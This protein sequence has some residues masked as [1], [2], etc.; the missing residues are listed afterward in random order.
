MKFER[1][2]LGIA[3][4]LSVT[5]KHMFRHPTVA[6]YPEQKL[7][8]SR[9]IRGNELVWD[10]QKC[11]GCG[12]CAKT[13]PQ[14]VIKIVTSTNRVNNRYEVEKYQVDT[15]YCIQCGLCVESCPYQTLF[16]GYAYERAKYR[17]GELVQNMEDMMLES[18]KKQPSGYFYPEIAQELPRQTLLVER[19]TEEE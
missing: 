15:G 1:Y 9:R 13:C 6:Q 7:N 16:M 17:R 2:G 8:T 14:G 18:G 4:G 10:R 19:I 3:K 5:L 12:T 11:T